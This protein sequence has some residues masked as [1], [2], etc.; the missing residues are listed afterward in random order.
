[1]KWA[2]SKC[3]LQVDLRN[4]CAPKVA[5][6]IIERPSLLRTTTMGPDVPPAGFPF[7]GQSPQNLH[8]GGQ[9]HPSPAKAPKSADLLHGQ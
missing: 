8:A 1:M 2:T 9:K 6:R 3:D 5:E 7:F 4:Q